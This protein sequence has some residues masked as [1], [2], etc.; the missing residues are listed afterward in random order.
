MRNSTRA[1]HRAFGR[2]FVL[3]GLRG[4]WERNN[5][6]DGEQGNDKG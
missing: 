1:L 4:R 5:S 3:V 2:L 6:S